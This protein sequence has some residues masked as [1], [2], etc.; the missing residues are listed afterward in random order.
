MLKVIDKRYI[1]IQDLIMGAAEAHLLPDKIHSSFMR[2]KIRTNKI[3]HSK[4]ITQTRREKKEGNAL[5]DRNYFLN[6][7]IAL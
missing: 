5:I 1:C 7:L 4:K 3:Q 2:L 6:S